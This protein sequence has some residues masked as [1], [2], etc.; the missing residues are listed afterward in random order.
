MKNFTVVAAWC[1]RSAANSICVKYRYGA[2]SVACCV[3][4][5]EASIINDVSGFRDLEIMRVAASCDAELVVMHSKQ[6][7]R[8]MFKTLNTM[9][10]V[11]ARCAGASS[12]RGSGR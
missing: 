5:C 11:G 3:R 8:T 12:Y 7:N 9:M 2:T 4:R 10:D 6:A 1:A